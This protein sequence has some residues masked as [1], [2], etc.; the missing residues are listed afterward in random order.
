MALKQ[1]HVYLPED[2]RKTV[3]KDA[4]EKMIPLAVWLKII[5]ANYYLTNNNE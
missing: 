2:L 5:V 4:K 3:E 1:L